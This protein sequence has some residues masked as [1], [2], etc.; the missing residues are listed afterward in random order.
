MGPTEQSANVTLVTPVKI[1]RFLVKISVKG[2]I[3]L[4]VQKVYQ[5]QLHMVAIL[6]EHVIIFL[7]KEITIHGQ[8]FVHTSQNR[9]THHVIVKMIMIV[10]LLHVIQMGNVV[11]LF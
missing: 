7:K 6:Q 9:L 2:L 3:H 11:Y 4:D 10:K 8:D 5:I 1:V